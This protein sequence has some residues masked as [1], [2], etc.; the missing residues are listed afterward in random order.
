M[1][2][3]AKVVDE[4]VHGHLNCCD[5]YGTYP[6]LYDHHS[7]LGIGED[8]AIQAFLKIYCFLASHRPVPLG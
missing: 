6:L 1:M 5:A 8:L 7:T 4:R 2:G 3:A